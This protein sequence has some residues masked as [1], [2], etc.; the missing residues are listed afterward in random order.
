M[1]ADPTRHLGD[2]DWEVLHELRLRGLVAFDD[3]RH[4]RLVELDLVAQRGAMVALT[5][6]GRDVHVGWARYDE[7]SPAQIAAKALFEAFEPLNQELLVVCSSWQVRTGGVPND[8]SDAAYD[9][10]VIG[11]LERF[12]E[13]SAPRV[14]RLARD[15]ARF[16]AYDVRLRHALRNVVDEGATEWFTSPRVDSYHTVWNQLHEDLLLALGIPRTTS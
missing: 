9:W 16:G 2:A 6:L 4:G 7:G 15:A 13:R 8:H 1:N 5:G 10:E 12:H 11:R 14:R 3:P